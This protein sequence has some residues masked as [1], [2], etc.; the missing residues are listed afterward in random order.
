MEDAGRVGF[1][2]GTSA[3][4]LQTFHGV[5]TKSQITIGCAYTNTFQKCNLGWYGY[6][7]MGVYVRLGSH[8]Q[9]LHFD[10][11]DFHMSRQSELE[12]N[13]SPF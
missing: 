13:S 2:E 8:T 5:E 1:E 9:E 12:E 3:A 11:N 7:T 4:I 6:Q 10:F